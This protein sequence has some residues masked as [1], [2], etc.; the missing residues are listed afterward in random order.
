MQDGETEKGILISKLKW[1]THYIYVIIN[2]GNCIL[3]NIPL[4][5]VMVSASHF[6]A[7]PVV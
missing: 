4:F 7:M 6:L 1:E 2:V 3:E 5:V